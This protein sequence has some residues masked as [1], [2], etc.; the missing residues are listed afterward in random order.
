MTIC[1]ILFGGSR[2]WYLDVLANVQERLSHGWAREHFTGQEMLAD[3]GT[4]PFGGCWLDYLTT[5]VRFGLQMPLPR[6][7]QPP[8]LLR[9]PLSCQACLTFPKVQSRIRT[10]FC[11]GLLESLPIGSTLPIGFSP[12]EGAAVTF[13]GFC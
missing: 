3:I 4:K 11:L 8:R 5:H 2:S 1:Q 10:L 13:L 6:R 9:N 12:A 7:P